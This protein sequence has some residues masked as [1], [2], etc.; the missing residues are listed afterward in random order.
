ME[1]KGC[2]IAFVYIEDMNNVVYTERYII[3]DNLT[4]TSSFAVKLSKHESSTSTGTSTR[5][6]M[7]RQ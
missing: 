6:N 4:F 5:R 3:K 7:A 1:F 2:V